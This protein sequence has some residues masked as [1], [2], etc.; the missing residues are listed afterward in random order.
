MFE[1]P[2]IP[3]KRPGQSAAAMSASVKSEQYMAWCGEMSEVGNKS[4]QQN[5]QLY[6]QLNHAG[7]PRV[8]SKAIYPTVCGEEVAVQSVNGKTKTK[9]R[10]C[11]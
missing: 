7:I 9:E 1:E 2:V 5:I 8:G 4:C 11:F 3:S 6:T 10:M